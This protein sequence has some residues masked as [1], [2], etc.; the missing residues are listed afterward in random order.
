M[1]HVEP[2]GQVQNYEVDQPPADW[3]V[4]AADSTLEQRCSACTAA[5]PTWWVLLLF[6]ANGLEALMA[7]APCVVAY[8][9]GRSTV[10]CQLRASHVACY[11]TPSH[12]LQA[13][14]CTAQA[15]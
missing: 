5:E 9:L 14:P 12:M 2:A 10:P 7:W 1:K 15:V 11:P 8:T 3:V 6:L 4:P 13:L